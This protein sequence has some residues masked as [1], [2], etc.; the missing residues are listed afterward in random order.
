MLG[1]ELQK[2]VDALLITL[3]IL[4]PDQVVEED[5]H[6][7]HADVLSPAELAIDLRRVEAIALPH[8]N[9]IDC[10]LGDVVAAD[11]PGLGAVPLVDH[12][13]VPSLRGGDEIGGER[14]R[15]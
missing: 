4:L 11:E 1:G 13:F 2:G 6:G 15:Q 10:V 7:V 5:A 12:L 14:S 9:L 8:F 3:G